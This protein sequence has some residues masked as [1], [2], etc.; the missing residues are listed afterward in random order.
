M[1]RIVV[2]LAFAL[3][4]TS[5]WAET[6]LRTA[7]LDGIAE[8]FE[9]AMNG[10][11]FAK[12]IGRTFDITLEG[13]KPGESDGKARVEC[14]YRVD[15]DLRVFFI[16][17]TK[18]GPV[19]EVQVQMIQGDGVPD[20]DFLPR[21]VGTMEGVTAGI[22]GR[23]FEPAERD[24]AQQLFAKFEGNRPAGMERMDMP[25]TAMTFLKLPN[26]PVRVLW[27]LK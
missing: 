4:A 26:Q 6:P 25:G 9:A 7:P 22:L 5:A 17:P 27:T 2:A 20:S 21:F 14:I 13:C 11:A 19:R 1:R 15:D 18:E 12:Q 24:R 8:P 23:D 3:L 16:A 10:S